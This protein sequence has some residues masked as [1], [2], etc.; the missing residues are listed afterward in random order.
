MKLA[1]PYFGEMAVKRLRI[2]EL[3][4]SLFALTQWSQSRLY[5]RDVAVELAQRRLDTWRTKE[6]LPSR[7]V[8]AIVQ[9]PDGYLWL[10]SRSGLVRFDGVDFHVYNGSNTPELKSGMVRSIVVSPQGELWIGTDGDGFG[11]FAGG[12]FSPFK[13]QNATPGWCEQKAL[14]FATDGSLW[15]GQRGANPL[16]H[17]VG[18]KA[19][20]PFEKAQTA[21]AIAQDKSGNIWVAG[22]APGA[23]VQKPDGSF[24]SFTA[25]EGLPS[26]VVGNCLFADSDGT[27]WVGSDGAGLFQYKAGRFY[28]FSRADGLRSLSI[29]VIKRDRS[30]RLWVGAQDGLYWLDN[31]RLVRYSNPEG[32]FTRRV[33]AI[34]EDREENLWV[35]NDVYLHRFNSAKM[36][37]IDLSNA[38][39]TLQ[40]RAICKTKDGSV[41]V[42]TTHGIT[43][44]LNG[45]RIVYTAADGLPANSVSSV[46][47]D[48]NEAVWALTQGGRYSRFDGRRFTPIQKQLDAWQIGA[49]RRGLVIADQQ[50]RFMRYSNGEFLPLEY[51]EKHNY[52]FLFYTDSSGQLWAASDKGL[53]KIGLQRVET[54]Q[55]GLPKDAHVLGMVEGATSGEIWFCTDKGVGR[56]FMGRLQMW[57]KEDGLPDSNLYQIQRDSAN[58]LW[59][60]SNIGV[61]SVPVRELLSVEHRPVSYKIYDAMHGI[62]HFPITM[63]SVQTADGRMWFKGETGLTAF[64][65]LH[66]P[67][68]ETAPTVHL[69]KFVVAKKEYSDNQFISLSPGKN[70]IEFH[71]TGISLSLPERVKFRYRLLGYDQDWVFAGT[72][73]VAYYTNLPP[74][75]YVFQL[76]AANEDGVW[77]RAVSGATFQ[78]EPYYYQ[79]SWFRLS[80]LFAIF[81]GAAGAYRW[82]VQ[83]FR[84]YNQI[85]E[86]RVEARTAELATSYQDLRQLHNSLEEMNAELEAAN[87]EMIASNAELAVAN[88]KLEEANHK[89]AM[90]ATT[91]GLT[92]LDNHRAFQEKLRHEMALA[93]RMEWSVGLLLLD[94]DYFKQYN[95]TYGHP[96]GDE[97]LRT[98]GRLLKENVRIVD[99]VARYGGEEFAVILPNTDTQGVFEIGERIRSVIAEY[100]FPNR[101]ITLSIGAAV[102]HKHEMEAEAFVECAD[103]ALYDSKRGGRNRLTLVEEQP[104]SIAA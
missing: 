41:W 95:D 28:N 101:E 17:V 21:N 40:T 55:R 46:C 14:F 43:R 69:E 22:V 25:K 49:D 99:H 63:G 56:Y 11:R 79:T 81:G 16:I 89:L 10:A 18:G 26:G 29:N 15:V 19:S 6:G 71:Y 37:P 60:G 24:H 74:G 36:T 27:V 52:I 78:L 54:I 61:F 72:R 91:D 96:A 87:D 35:C 86:K 2:L 98:L 92:G 103:M 5:G 33:G 84:R 104:R 68:N 100:T 20:Y 73:H 59:L 23:A 88:Y 38:D 75:K 80:C 67:F 7:G 48:A 12:K 93:I 34:L 58:N 82:R 77:S 83:R 30:G 39:G 42:G 1:R 85:L 44:L 31:S 45:T 66:L 51:R 32:L 102:L 47:T 57:G 8:D 97:V 9:A 3:A 70:N 64:D 65:P 4:F 90:L 94:V 53:H 13:P 62:R 50:G 76:K